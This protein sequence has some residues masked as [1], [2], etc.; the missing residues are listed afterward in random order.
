[1]G[2]LY[3]RFIERDDLDIHKWHD[4]FPVYE[5][6]FS[7][8]RDRKPRMLEIGVE[9][10]GSL[11]LF[12]DWLGAGALITGADIDPRCRSFAVPGSIEIEIGDQ[13]DREFLKSLVQKHGPWDIILDDGGHTDNQIITSFETLFPHLNNGGIYLIEDTHAHFFGDA[14]RDHPEKRS[15]LTLV[16]ELFE[17]M[18]TW[19]GDVSRFEHWHVPPPE[20][21]E[22]VPVPDAARSIAAV[23]LYDSIIV[24][25][26]NERAE[27]Y[28]ERRTKGVPRATTYR[29]PGADAA[30]DDSQAE[31]EQT[32]GSSAS[33]RLAAPMRHL[34]NLLKWR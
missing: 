8:F 18:H 9:R 33:W 17:L 15:V 13:A 26:K 28:C 19:T 25:E 14:F 5:R 1:M 20:R 22:P 29:V 2:D 12:A 4:Y 7:R 21:R 34:G 27:P 11:R 6:Y 16:S 23:H 3:R 31:H 30:R 24:I 32:T 10:G